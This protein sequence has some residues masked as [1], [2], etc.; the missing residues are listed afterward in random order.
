MAG[1]GSRP[2]EEF[3]FVLDAGALDG[4]TQEVDWSGEGVPEF[5]WRDVRPIPS[6]DD[7][8]E[9]VW[10]SFRTDQGGGRQVMTAPSAA[11][12]A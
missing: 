7:F 1:P 4:V 11:A 3:R 12:E 9:N 6:D 8:F 5:T 10:R 2:A